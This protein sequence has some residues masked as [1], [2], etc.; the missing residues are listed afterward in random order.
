MKLVSESPRRSGLLFVLEGIDGAGKTVVCD[1]LI[2]LLADEGRD[3]V[4]LREPTSES[5]WGK[6]IRERTPRGELT[7]SEELELYMRDREWH[8][9]NRIK[10]A[11]AAGKI[12]LM[13][14]YFFAAGAYQSTSTGL[15]WSEIVR[16]NREEIGAPEPDIVFLLNVPVEVGLAR[17]AAAR[18]GSLNVQFEKHDRLAKVR[19]AYLE[20]AAEDLGNFTVI[21]ATNELEEVVSEVYTRVVDFIRK[22]RAQDTST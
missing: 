11:L 14:R 2:E 19:Q 17:I 22:H 12:V 10:P 21:D 5:P 8:I 7:P 15:H 20:M 1:R 18:E 3:V 6:E 4:R 13:D 16:R 9:R